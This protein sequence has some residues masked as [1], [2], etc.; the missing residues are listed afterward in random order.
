MAA[1]E[2]DLI[3][4][5]D[6]DIL[7]FA[8]RFVVGLVGPLLARPDIGFVKGFYDRRSTAARTAAAGSPSWWRG[9]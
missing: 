4:W 3:V 6:A 8:A 1:A 9:R 7:D 5:C 2:G